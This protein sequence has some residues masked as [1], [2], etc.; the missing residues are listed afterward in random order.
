MEPTSDRQLIE[1][2]SQT[3]PSTPKSS[4][5]SP[6]WQTH[7]TSRLAKMASRAGR[8]SQV[9]TSMPRQHGT[10][11]QTT[12][13]RHQ[14]T[15]GPT[16]AAEFEAA[17]LDWDAVHFTVLAE[18][19][20][21]SVAVGEDADLE[22]CAMAWHD[23]S[24][25]ARRWAE[26][27]GLE[28]ELNPFDRTTYR[29]REDRNAAGAVCAITPVFD[30]RDVGVWWRVVVGQGTSEDECT[31]WDEI[32]TRQHWTWS[33]RWE[34]WADWFARMRKPGELALRLEQWCDPAQWP[35]A[36]PQVPPAVPLPTWEGGTEGP[37][38][39]ACDGEPHPGQACP[40]DWP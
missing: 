11:M 17:G 12:V 14:P 24:A 37:H 27:Q 29:D 31:T 19:H 15:T 38:T 6:P 26:S 30:R 9:L 3:N 32:A 36:P 40:T 25:Q 1:S 28:V 20:E 5:S 10:T 13:T 39:E 4:T 21:L 22:L 16:S 34:R 7:L 35:P 2:L 8:I 23:L 18:T 33:A